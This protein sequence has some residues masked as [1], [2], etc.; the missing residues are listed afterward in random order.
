MG[1]P[2][3]ELRRSTIMA[4]AVPATAIR[5]PATPL[6]PRARPVLAAALA[7]TLLA[8]APAT[9]IAQPVDSAAGPAEPPA[10]ID[11]HYNHK[12]YQPTTG[13]VCDRASSDSIDCA[14]RA[15]KDAAAK[16]ESVQ[17]Q[18]DELAKEYPPEP[19]TGSPDGRH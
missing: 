16:L 14:T 5:R 8:I 4:G 18:L 17:R 15:G 6:R 10:R 1:M 7:G 11:N 2:P 9:G 19:T 3:L 12:A 13:A